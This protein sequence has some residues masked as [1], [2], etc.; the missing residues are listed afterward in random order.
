MWDTFYSEWDTFYI[1]WDNFYI[2][3]DTFY[4][5]YENL[6]HS[7]WDNLSH[8]CP[9]QSGTEVQL[10]PVGQVEL[11]PLTDEKV[12][13]GLMFIN[14]RCARARMLKITLTVTH[15]TSCTFNIA[16]N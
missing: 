4:S 9:T 8:C 6:S 7:E 13:P 3:W 16:Q 10:V 14:A 11:V 2:E 15:V 1:E 5:E 12:D